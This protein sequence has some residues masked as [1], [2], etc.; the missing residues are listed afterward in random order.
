MNGIANKRVLV[1]GAA[2]GIGLAVAERFLSEGALV[3]LTDAAPASSINSIVDS[4]EGRYPGLA[5]G[6]HMAIRDE[7][8]VVEGFS[9]MREALGGCDILVNNAGINRQNPSH[10]FTTQDFDQVLGVNPRVAFLCSREALK[11]FLEQGTGIILNTPQITRSIRIRN[12]S[13]IP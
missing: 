9:Y 2:Q 6:T 13:L 8:Q 7:Q 3:L 4:L 11:L 12:S 1:T 10:A 5:F